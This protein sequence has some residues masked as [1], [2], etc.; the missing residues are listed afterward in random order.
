MT[1]KQKLQLILK[2]S[3]LTQTQLANR[4]GVTFAALNRWMN[5]KAVPRPKALE[6]IDE[7]YLLYAGFLF[8]IQGSR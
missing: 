6:K 4:L 8:H 3:G 1:P 5:N 2:L 7:F